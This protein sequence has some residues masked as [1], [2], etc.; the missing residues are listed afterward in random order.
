MSMKNRN[1]QRLPKL[2]SAVT[3]YND[4]ENHMKLKD[5]RKKMPLLQLRLK[6]R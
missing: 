6:E 2:S 5:K 4:Y 1:K 3:A